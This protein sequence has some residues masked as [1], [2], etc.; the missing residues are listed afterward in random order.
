VTADEYNARQIRRGKVSIGELAPLLADGVRA[1]Q[2]ARGLV[3]DGRLGPKTLALLRRPI[4]TRRIWPLAELSYGRKAK[5]TSG[6][7]TGDRPGH[8]GVDIMF[9]AH[10]GSDRW[11]YKGKYTCEGPVLA[12]AAGIVSHIS[13]RSNGWRMWIDHADSDGLRTGYFHLGDV[14]V[15]EGDAVDVGDAVAGL[16]K[17][18]DRV[19]PYHLHFE[20]SVIGR[21]APR[22]PAAW[23]AAAAHVKRLEP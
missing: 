6:F 22:D 4:I 15:S 9:D 20:V 21:Y 17:D 2:R 1:W 5:I 3:P 8:N 19:W 7:R 23:L 16:C 12:A 11:T 14:L 10:R 13:E 18:Q